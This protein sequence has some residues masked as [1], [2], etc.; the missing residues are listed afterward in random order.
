L[1][2]FEEESEVNGIFR[3]KIREQIKNIYP[4][5][6]GVI[7][8]LG[9][10]LARFVASHSLQELTQI[11][12]RLRLIDVEDKHFSVSTET[13]ERARDT[14]TLAYAPAS[15]LLQWLSDGL[16]VLVMPRQDFISDGKFNYLV[17]IDREVFSIYIPLTKPEQRDTIEIGFEEL[18]EKMKNNPSPSEFEAWV[19]HSLEQKGKAEK[20]QAPLPTTSSLEEMVNVAFARWK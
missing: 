9:Y 7:S 19:Y 2:L 13:Q 11:I 4:Q 5:P 8:V 1:E 14:A 10:C 12:E 20:T 15:T 18:R 17:D 16:S 6:F 3:F